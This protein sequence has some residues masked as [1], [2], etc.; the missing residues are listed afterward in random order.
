[1]LEN[2]SIY[3]AYFGLNLNI[4]HGRNECHNQL[5][6]SMIEPHKWLAQ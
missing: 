5:G 4:F 1:M 2:L 3:K 6:Q